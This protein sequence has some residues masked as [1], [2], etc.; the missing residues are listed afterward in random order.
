[1]PRVTIITRTV[2]RPVLLARA[3]QSILAQTFTGWHWIVV[4]S[5]TGDSAA[6]LISRHEHKLKGRVTHLRFTNPVPG[7]RGTA[8]N[9][10]I[11]A[12]QG[13][14]ITLLDDDD[15]WEPRFLEKMIAA[16]DR[17]TH[18]N[19]RGVVC[20]TLCIEES[21][22]ESGLKV[23]RTYELNPDLCN[24]TLGSLAVV[25][26]FC[27]HAFLY[28][29]DALNSVGL[30]PEDY[31][32]LE[33][34]HFNLRF[35]LQYE[36]IVVPEFLTNYHLRITETSDAQANSQTAELNDHK[37]HEARLINEALREDIRT[38]KP[39]LG[40]VLA[41][42]AMLR[43]TKDSLHRHEGRLKSIGDKSGKIDA[44]TKELKDRLLGKR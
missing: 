13:E 14:L 20:R 2:D 34:W 10:G 4:D 19:A 5:S 6:E 21:S 18:P 29:R 24:I 35:L 44:R 31:P 23:E 9:A 40:L 7:M 3:L 42:A 37:Y 12:S 1:M 43:E 32:V 36:I 38:G 39:G 11:N 8:I 30:Y 41:H 28:Q 27:T 26:R 25:N 15:T 17:G 16:L 22:V 33:D